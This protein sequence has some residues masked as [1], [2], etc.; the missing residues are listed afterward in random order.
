M[1]K[2]KDREG[3]NCGSP[4][5]S[6][7]DVPDSSKAVAPGSRSSDPPLLVSRLRVLRLRDINPP[8]TEFDSIERP[9]DI[10]QLTVKDVEFLNCCAYLTNVYRSHITSLGKV[11]LG[12]IN[13]EDGKIVKVAL[14]QYEQGDSQT[15]V[16]NAVAS[17]AP[18]AV[19]CTGCCGRL[20]PSRAELGD[21][22]IS[23]KLVTYDHKKIIN[24]QEQNRGVRVN[25]TRHMSR[26]IR[27]ADHGWNPPVQDPVYEGKVHKDK[28]VLSG[29]ESVNDDQ[30]K[31]FLENYRKAVG[32]ETEG[33]GTVYHLSVVL[34]YH[35]MR[36]FK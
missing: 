4:V 26:L 19:I 32:I 9:I 8:F 2:S 14:L 7:S 20:D 21:V 13:S 6:S 17:L 18:K 25:V 15:V 30:R 3:S 5:S 12:E 29:S 34:Y 22:V 24:G 35:Y 23:S 33:G 1:S 31:Q 27:T 36:Q 11:Y 16:R 28:D 10:V